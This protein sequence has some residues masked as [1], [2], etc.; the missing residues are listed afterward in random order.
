MVMDL[1]SNL[2]LNWL[3]AMYSWLPYPLSSVVM[4][5]FCVLFGLVIVDI[6]KICWSFVGRG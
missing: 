4:G 3:S 6:V 5:L 1:N 2:L